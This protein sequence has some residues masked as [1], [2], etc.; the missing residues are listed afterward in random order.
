VALRRVSTLSWRPVL[1][2]RKSTWLATGNSQTAVVGARCSG[3]KRYCGAG[4]ASRAGRLLGLTRAAW[5]PAAGD[6]EGARLGHE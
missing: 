3:P 2:L 5:T 4:P 6:E 1:H